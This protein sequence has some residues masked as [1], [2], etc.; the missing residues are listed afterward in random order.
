MMDDTGIEPA[1]SVVDADVE[2]LPLITHD[3]EIRVL[4]I[5]NENYESCFFGSFHTSAENEKIHTT[6][7]K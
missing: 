5:A 3:S 2:P 1:F 6:V 4:Y 7:K